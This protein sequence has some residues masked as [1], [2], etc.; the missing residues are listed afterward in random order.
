MEE[1]DLLSFR[2]LRAYTF[3][4]HQGMSSSRSNE[5]RFRAAVR[6]RDAKEVAM[7]RLDGA[8]FE[9]TPCIGTD[10]L[11]SCSVVLVVSAFAAILGHVAPRPD[12]SNVANENA[13]DN[14]IRTFMGNFVGYY[15]QSAAYF[16]AGSNSWV[17]CAAFGGAIALP[18]QQRIM[19]NYLRDAGL[20]VDASQTYK[21]PFTAEHADRGS[22]FVDSRGDR[23]RVYVENREIW[24]TQRIQASNTNVAVSMANAST[25]YSS[26]VS[27]NTSGQHSATVVAQAPAQQT[28]QIADGWVWSAEHQRRWWRNADGSFRQWQD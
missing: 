5:S 9:S 27:T 12:N 6:N 19:E 20:D 10:G 3:Q 13:G 11:G 8:V 21:V 17:V 15:R 7:N 23:V 4:P 1:T 25:S 24:S 2:Q 22:V 26:V 18:D 28:A 16:P 14:H